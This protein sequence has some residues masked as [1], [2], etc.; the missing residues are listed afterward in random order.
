MKQ[1]GIDFSLNSTGIC[2]KDGDKYE[3]CNVTNCKTSLHKKLYKEVTVTSYQVPSKKDEFH[4]MLRYGMIVESVMQFIKP[5]FVKGDRIV[6][7]GYS[8]Q[9]KGRSFIDLISAQSFLR[10]ELIAS[11]SCFPDIVPPKSLKKKFTGTGNATKLVM[12][13]K[14]FEYDTVL[15]KRLQYINE[16]ELGLVTKGGKLTSP[17]S[18]LIDAF[19]LANV[20]IDD[21][22]DEEIEEDEIE[23]EE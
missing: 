6:I 9:G 1:F 16:N 5:R 23:T 15:G 18:D 7:E 3:Y 4:K 10:C 12:M 14:F 13:D 19:A 20:D 2:V 21:Y 11:L 22:E 8:Y 17:I